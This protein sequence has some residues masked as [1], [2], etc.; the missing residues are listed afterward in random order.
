MAAADTV[1]VAA[2]SAAPSTT[3][4]W[5]HSAR[6]GHRAAAADLRLAHTLQAHPVTAAA[7]AAGRVDPAQAAVITSAVDALPATLDTSG[8]QRG[9]THLV[10]LAASLDAARLQVAGRHLLEVLDPETADLVEGRRLAAEE[11]RARRR[12]YLQVRDN[13]D[14]T[15]TGRFLIPDLHAAILTKALWALTSPRRRATLAATGDSP[16]EHA[17][18]EKTTTEAAE[19]RR[20]RRSG[21]AGAAGA[22]G[23][24]GDTVSR[25]AR[26]VRLT[27]PEVA[28]IGFCELLERLTDRDLPAASGAGATVVVTMSLAQLEDRLNTAGIATLDT[29]GTL[30]AGEARRLACTAGVIPAV[31]D[32]ASAVLDLG[33]RA[34]LHSKA[35]RLALTLRDQTCTTLGCDRPA[36]WCETHHDNGTWA[37]GAPTNLDHGRLLCSWHHHKAHDPS[38]DMHHH[39]DGTVRFTMRR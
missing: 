12:C 19:D 20:S 29:G 4:W 25:S 31:L 28:G 18:T 1:D 6:I 23:A 9:E 30:S 38:Y 11:R 2:A 33:R 17:A 35:Q 7:L 26:A 39:P 37:T 24:A 27:R 36:A 15:H 8:R 21:P 10:E 3:A 16:Y 22:A 13:H 32:S 14:G 5:R 34:R